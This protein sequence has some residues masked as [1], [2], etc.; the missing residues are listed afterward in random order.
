MWEC[1]NRGAF[2]LRGVCSLVNGAEVERIMPMRTN[3]RPHLIP[4]HPRPGTSFQSKVGTREPPLFLPCYAPG[5]K[6][7]V[8]VSNH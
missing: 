5:A 8:N 1:F 6:R 4:P 7:K 3:L 2:K